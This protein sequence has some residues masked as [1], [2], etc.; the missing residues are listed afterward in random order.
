MATSSTR[1]DRPQ[2]CTARLEVHLDPGTQTKIMRFVSVFRR[3]QSVVLR[4]VL[5]WGLSHGQ[6][7]QVDRGHR[8][9]PHHSF[10]R[11]EP[12]VRQQVEVAA[13]TAGG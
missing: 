4:H 5:Q 10:L 13:T 8:P 6:G 1:R 9:A 12:E 3:R 7:W 2:R 11:L